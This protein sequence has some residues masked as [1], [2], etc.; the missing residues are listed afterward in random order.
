MPTFHKVIRNFYD[1]YGY[2]I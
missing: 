1:R 2:P